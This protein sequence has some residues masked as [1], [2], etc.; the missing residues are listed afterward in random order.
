M[1]QEYPNNTSD[2]SP[3]EQL[4]RSLLQ[5]AQGDPTLLSRPPSTEVE[6]HAAATALS[7]STEAVEAQ[8]RGAAIGLNHVGRAL[9]T[10][11]YEFRFGLPTGHA[12]S[13]N[14][15]GSDRPPWDQIM[16]GALSSAPPV[17]SE[18]VAAPISKVGPS[19]KSSEA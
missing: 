18:G 1:V 16:G 14:G 6:G 7:P 5:C 2:L 19:L 10:P 4:A 17:L 8:V 12:C 15:L 3:V 13:P 9:G 11:P